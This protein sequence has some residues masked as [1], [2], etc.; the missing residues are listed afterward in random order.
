MSTPTEMPASVR[1]TLMG[2]AVALGIFA[3][4]GNVGHA[5]DAVRY[6]GQGP[7]MAI[8][9][10]LMPDVLLV[11]SVFK[12]RYNRR[13]VMAYVGLMCSVGFLVWASLVSARS[14]LEP[15]AADPATRRA[16]S[17]SPLI[18]AIVAA[19]LIE[20]S[21]AAALAVVAPDA[22]KRRTKSPAATTPPV[23][24]G[25][26][27]GQETAPPPGRPLHLAGPGDQVGDHLLSI[28]QT[29]AKQLI[30]E[31][32]LNRDNLVAAIRAAGHTCSNQRG[33]DLLKQ[34][35]EGAA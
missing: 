6:A 5:F 13:S 33:S 27:A 30:K 1:K 26:T 32:R 31:Q 24:S 10:A 7:K 35:K 34:I 23:V 4:G 3:A 14:H 11:L 29:A 17:L 20:S 2:A 8:A 21:P 25:S 9:I 19:G 18:G 16:V 28:A 15:G 22:K 12:W